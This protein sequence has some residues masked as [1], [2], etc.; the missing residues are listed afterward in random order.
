[1]RVIIDNSYFVLGGGSAHRKGDF[2]G[3][4][5]LDLENFLECPSPYRCTV[6]LV[7]SMSTAIGMINVCFCVCHSSL[8]QQLL[9][10]C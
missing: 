3:E 7:L 4:G 9:G 8:S 1:V 5:V 2:P 6:I 10:C